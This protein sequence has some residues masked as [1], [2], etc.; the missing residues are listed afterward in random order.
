MTRFFLILFFIVTLLLFFEDT[1][2]AKKKSEIRTAFTLVLTTRTSY[3][4]TVTY[5]LTLEDVKF[6]FSRFSPHNC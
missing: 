5:G 2:M 6:R 4:M 3:R 1:T